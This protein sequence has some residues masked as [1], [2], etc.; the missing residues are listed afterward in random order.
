[1]YF[2]NPFGITLIFN[3]NLSS[4][5]IMKYYRNILVNLKLKLQLLW[6]AP[7]NLPVM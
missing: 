7:L 6:A 2:S 4:S 1:M 5:Q 3:S